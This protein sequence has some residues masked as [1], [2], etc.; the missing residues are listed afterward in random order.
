[1][2][3]SWKNKPTCE[4]PK[5][6]AEILKT[7]FFSARVTRQSNKLTY[8]LLTQAS[9]N[10]PHL[11]IHSSL[12]FEKAVQNEWLTLEPSHPDESIMADHD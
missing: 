7:A 12:L 9:L 10:Q 8:I 5:S 1:M 4:L 6:V 3:P 2:D 11:Y